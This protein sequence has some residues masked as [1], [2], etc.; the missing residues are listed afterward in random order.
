MDFLNKMGLNVSQITLRAEH[1][2]LNL[3][4]RLKCASHSPFFFT[5]SQTLVIRLIKATQGQQ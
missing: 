4:I 1:T 5:H 3:E 2:I